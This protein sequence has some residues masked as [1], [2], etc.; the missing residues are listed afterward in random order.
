MDNLN[1]HSTASMYKAFE[2]DIARQIA[3]RLEI[4]DTPI[5]ASWLNMAEEDACHFTILQNTAVCPD[6]VYRL[7][8]RTN[9]SKAAPK[10]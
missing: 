9:V 6:N 2:P 1:I 8:I 10:D 7:G 4:H 5:H 3:Q